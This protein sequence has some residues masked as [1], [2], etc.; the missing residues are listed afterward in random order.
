MYSKQPPSPPLTPTT[1]ALLAAN[2]V[3]LRSELGLSQGA[4]ALKAGLHRTFVPHVERQARIISLDNIEKLAKA[5][6]VPVDALLAP[7]ATGMTG[8][9]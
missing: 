5:L 9:S 4:L 6:G 3:R 7:R 2:V 1:R 8:W